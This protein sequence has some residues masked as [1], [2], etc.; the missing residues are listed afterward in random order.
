MNTQLIKII[1]SVV[2]FFLLTCCQT[3]AQNQQDFSTQKVEGRKGVIVDALLQVLNEEMELDKFVLNF[4]QAER[5]DRIKQVVNDLI[6]LTGGAKYKG[7]L[8]LGPPRKNMEIIVIEDVHYNLQRKIGLRFSDTPKLLLESLRYG[9]HFGKKKAISSSD[10]LKK[11]E[12]KQNYLSKQDLFSGTVLVAFGDSILY[13]RASGEASKRYKV[14]NNTNTKFN[15]ASMGK[16]FTA[17]SILQLK[18]KGLLSLEDKLINYVDT[19]WIK[20][21]I[22]SQITIENLLTHTSGLGDCFTQDFFEASRER[23]RN[24]EDYQ[25]IISKDTLQFTPGT[26]YSYSNNGMILL[27]LVIEKVSELSYE[28]YLKKNIFEPAKMQNTGLFEMD[29]AI[30]NIA[31]GYWKETDATIYRSNIFENPIKGTPAG[32]GY[33]TVEDMYRFI[34]ALKNKIL[35]SKENIDLLWEPSL[36][37]RVG[38][39]F[40]VFNPAHGK[41]VGHAGGFTG[42]SAELIYD[43]EKDIVTV[44]LS[45]YDNGLELSHFI[46]SKI[47]Q[48]IK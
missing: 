30:E 36:H 20:T 48:V 13:Q 1:G 27:G 47:N 15:L 44:V 42:I 28:A 45:N 24:I 22:A 39:G 11:L 37:P 19:T 12:E 10:F 6:Q 8:S 43:I 2:F 46:R 23:F 3:E 26:K 4:C 25:P 34:Q 32:G 41:Q 40:Q 14:L 5:T 35:L 18:E 16:M 31:I 38:K 33:A 21:P 29:Q 17:V 7:I 9:I